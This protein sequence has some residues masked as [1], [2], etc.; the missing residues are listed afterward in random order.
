MAGHLGRARTGLRAFYL[1]DYAVNPLGVKSPDAVRKALEGWVRAAQGRASTLVVACNT[2]SARLEGASEVRGL[3]SSL[4]IRLFSMVDFL[5][6]TLKDSTREV[7]GK[8]VCLMGTEFTVGQGGYRKRLTEAGA[9]SIISLAATR[10]ERAIAHFRHESP[11]GRAQILEEVREMVRESETVL[12]ACTCFPLVGDLLRE[13]NPG[14]SLLDPGVGVESL[15]QIKGRKGPNLMTVGVTG[16]VLSASE[17]RRNFH[18]I[19]PGWELEEV[20][21]HSPGQSSGS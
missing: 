13:A 20:V 14:V 1:A 7:R 6:R 21:G 8:R 2:A 5:D 4:G 10:T 12:L 9:G 19:F 16:S 15:P 3:A 18:R 17:I 11:Q